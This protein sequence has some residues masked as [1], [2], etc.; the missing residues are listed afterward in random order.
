MTA[1]RLMVLLTV[2]Y[3]Y[4]K[5]LTAEVRAKRHVVEGR[6]ATWTTETSTVMGADQ[7]S[8]GLRKMSNQDCNRHVKMKN[9]KGLIMDLCFDG[10]LG[11][12]VE[13]KSPYVAR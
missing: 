6:T 2:S 1:H 11:S 13:E 5:M 10:S 4:W 8:V 7:Y 9:L 3:L 12:P